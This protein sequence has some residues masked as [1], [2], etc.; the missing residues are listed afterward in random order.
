MWAGFTTSSSFL[1][2]NIDCGLSSAVGAKRLD[3]GVMWMANA[4]SRGVQKCEL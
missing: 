2:E 3:G 1:R 4:L